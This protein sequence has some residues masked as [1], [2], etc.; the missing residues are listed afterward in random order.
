MAQA[1]SVSKKLAKAIKNQT[2][3]TNK[4]RTRDGGS[5]SEEEYSKICLQKRSKNK[6]H[7]QKRT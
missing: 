1:K 4:K 5:D 7:K 3:Q 6:L 2:S